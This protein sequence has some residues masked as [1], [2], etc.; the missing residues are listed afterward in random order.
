GRA[1]P[2]AAGDS[3][4]CA[5]RPR[6]EAP[7][8]GRGALRPLGGVLVGRDARRREAL[9]TP[10]GRRD[11]AAGDPLARGRRCSGTRRGS[12][13][14]QRVPAGVQARGLRPLAGPR[15]GRLAHAQAR[16]SG[17]ANLR[18][19]MSSPSANLPPWLVTALRFGLGAA[20]SLVALGGSGCVV[21][22]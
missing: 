13:G 5:P 10:E 1:G 3:R 2:A 19:S 8:R 18:A 16:A 4:S 15:A 14:V 22:G 7:G 6:A 20:G 11:R 21:L 9:A 12:A 17:C